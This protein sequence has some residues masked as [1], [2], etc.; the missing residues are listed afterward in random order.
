MC[1]SLNKSECTFSK[2]PYVPS[3]RYK[4]TL[5]KTLLQNFQSLIK[6]KIVKHLEYVKRQTIAKL[7]VTKL[8]DAV[9]QS[10]TVTFERIL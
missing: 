10:V 1:E 9:G 7:C 4:T 3:M 6:K 8:L 2:V 5:M